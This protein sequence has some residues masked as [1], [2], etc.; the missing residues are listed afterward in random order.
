MLRTLSLAHRPL[1]RALSTSATPTVTIAVAGAA[2]PLGKATLAKIAAGEMLGTEQKVA[3]TL[4][5]GD[6]ETASSVKSSP[7]VAS[8]T[9]ASS[10][11]AAFKG[12]QFAV[13]LSGD[14]AAMGKAMDGADPDVK[15]AVVGNTNAQVAWQASKIKGKHFSAVTKHVQMLAEKSLAASAGV[16]V[17]DVSN[18]IAWGS[19]IADVSHAIV[20][21]KWALSAGAEP[22]PAVGEADESIIADAIVGTVKAWV[23]GT[24]GDAWVCMGVPAAGDYGTGSGIFFSVPVFCSD[25]E[26]FR[27]GGVHMTAAVAEKL[28]ADRLAL[29]GEAK[30]AG[31]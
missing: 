27:V 25:G 1:A 8:V 14:F 29:L 31:K 12:A 9:S 4:L 24:K 26:Y 18:V 21:G 23:G 22:L 15:V 5:G 28:E 3:L 16:D 7:L 6:A 19:G 2:T 30:K 10:P 17:A 20:G 11:A 13:L